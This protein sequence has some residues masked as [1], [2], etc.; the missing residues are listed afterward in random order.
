MGSAVIVFISLVVLVLGVRVEEEVV[1]GRVPDVGVWGA[2]ISLFN[3]ISGEL[4]EFYEFD[5]RC[6]A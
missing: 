1:G 3:W 4:D 2:G 6:D 5:E